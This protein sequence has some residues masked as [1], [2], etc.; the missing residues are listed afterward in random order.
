MN[1]LHPSIQ[2]WLDT[3]TE[4]KRG[5]YLFGTTGTGKTHNLKILHERNRKKNSEFKFYNV[6][7]FINK[8]ALLRQEMTIDTSQFGYNSQM[9][10]KMLSGET[11][12]ILDDLGTETL[13]ERKLE[14]LYSVI[15]NMSEKNTTL[16]ISS[17]LSVQELERKVGDRICSRIV[18]M[19][20]IV[21]L[22]GEDRR[23]KN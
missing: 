23:F 17:N 14:D 19:C 3:R 4:E 13:S 15:N 16:I 10:T 18:G 11:P 22:S 2:N 5:L 12:L 21:E 1:K 6:P 8:I 7:E 9:I 20:H